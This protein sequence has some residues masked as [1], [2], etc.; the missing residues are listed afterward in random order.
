MRWLAIAALPLA[1]A[2]RTG[3][4]GQRPEAMRD[5]SPLEGRAGGEISAAGAPSR[6]DAGPSSIAPETPLK[7]SGAFLLGLERAFP[8]ARKLAK[9]RDQ[10]AAEQASI[11][12]DAL[13][14]AIESVPGAST[15]VA[16]QLTEV[17]F[18]AKRLHRSERLSLGLARWIAEG[19]TAATNALEALGAQGD[20][21]NF[22]I[23]QAR[24]STAAID[25]KSGLTFQRAVVQDATR[26]TLDAFSAFGRRSV[27]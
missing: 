21:S 24:A 4:S 7:T 17:R 23:A 15:R 26:A 16:D 19:L 6:V 1:C 18:Q 2:A 3:S 12:L 11:V 9:L 14:D 27:P 22:W 8:A 20:I 5:A 13:A 25:V 10:F